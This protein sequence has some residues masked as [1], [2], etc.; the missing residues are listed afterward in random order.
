MERDESGNIGDWGEKM[1]NCL[2]PEERT[3][4]DECFK[5]KSDELLREVCS[6]RAVLRCD[7]P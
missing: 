4:V 5:S 3:V 6:M 7:V 2:K 1:K